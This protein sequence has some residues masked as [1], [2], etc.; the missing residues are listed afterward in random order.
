MIGWWAASANRFT[1]R[2]ATTA[3]TNQKAIATLGF[4]Q[5][6]TGI[7][8]RNIKAGLNDPMICC[9]RKAAPMG[10]TNRPPD[11]P[12]PAGILCQAFGYRDWRSRFRTWLADHP[13]RQRVAVRLRSRLPVTVA[14]EE[15]GSVRV[16]CGNDHTVTGP[17][18]YRAAD[19][20]I[21]MSSIASQDASSFSCGKSLCG[22]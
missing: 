12:G 8:G 22:M 19:S 18:A 3:P 1:N 2:P 5:K 10:A 9:R 4:S 13:A 17:I 11:R 16:E 7:D 21:R 6:A 20:T 14:L 15:A